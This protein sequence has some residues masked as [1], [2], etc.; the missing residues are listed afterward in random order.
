MRT[1]Q[2]GLAFGVSGGPFYPAGAGGLWRRLAY[3]GLRPERTPW[4]LWPTRAK[5]RLPEAGPERG[6]GWWGPL[7]PVSP[8][9][10]AVPK[11]VPQSEDWPLELSGTPASGFCSEARE[12]SARRCKHQSYKV[13]TAFSRLV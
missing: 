11:E 3:A 13:F 8:P 10:R 1:R 6:A 4:G 9:R 5:E 2:Q 12:S 7:P